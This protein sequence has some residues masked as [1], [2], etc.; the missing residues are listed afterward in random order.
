MCYQNYQR[1]SSKQVVVFNIE[2]DRFD[3]NESIVKQY[4][5]KKDSEILTKRKTKREIHLQRDT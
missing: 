5:R 1:S 2:L 3:T 4:K